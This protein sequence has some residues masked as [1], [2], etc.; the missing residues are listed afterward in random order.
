LWLAAIVSNIGGWMQDTAGTWLMTSLTASPLLIALMQTAASLP[1]LL[2]GFVSGATAD[3]FDRRRLLV[4]WQSWMLFSVAVLSVLTLAGVV[5]PWTLLAFTFL[6]N[7]GNAL[8]GPA[9]QA[10]VPELVPR[11]ELPEAVSI[12]SAG[13]NLTRAVGPALGGLM[14]AAFA[15]AV[16]G[17]GIVF[18]LNAASFIAV[19]LVLYLW[20]RT[21][22][23]KSALPAE[24]LAGSL[25]AGIRYVQHA[26]SLQAI[27][28]RVFAFTLFASAIWALLAVVAQQDL[29]QGAMG[30][31]VLNGCLGFGAVTGAVLLPRVRKRL[32]ADHIVTI[33]SLIFVASLL[34]LALVHRVPAVVVALLATGMAWTSTTSTLNVSVQ[35]SVPAWV[36]AR[37]LGA[38]QTI[39]WAGMALGSWAWGY[40]A[41][42][43][44]TWKSLLAAAAGMLIA[45]PLVRPFHL[46][47]GAPPDMSPHQPPRSA[48]AVLVEP[49]P[50]DGPVLVSIEYLVD[51]EDYE[52]FIRA[53]HRMSRVRLRDGASR[54]GVFRDTAR[55]ERVVE[56]FVT[57]SWLEFLRERERL[58]ESD[59]KIR[60][61]VRRYHRGEDPPKASYMIYAREVGR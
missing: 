41:E 56:Q 4:F 54:W 50:D 6:L 33:S 45:Q 25:R 17:A 12:N 46:W 24:R 30:Y 7:I 3:I 36:Q 2:L 10:I 23:F 21:P 34:V 29:H 37:A 32:D 1:V 39:F 15:T 47:R 44:A 27:F 48:P 51:G 31:G 61:R 59:R 9:W 18:L 49:D 13:F 26:P 11:P 22:G 5:S 19:I 20:R 14:V 35:L 53:I 8:N 40:V 52:S 60:E 38:Y 16:R 57:E 43:S 28:V 55:P 58:T 42:H